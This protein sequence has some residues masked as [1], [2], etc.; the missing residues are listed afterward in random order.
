MA[1]KFCINC[2]YELP[3]I[4]K[5]CPACGT[6]QN[7]SDEEKPQDNKNNKTI[8]EEQE[9]QENISS[10]SDFLAKLG[11]LNSA[12]KPKKPSIIPGLN[13]G[14][15]YHGGTMFPSKEYKEKKD[16]KDEQNNKT[17]Q[18]I[19]SQKKEDVKTKNSENSIAQE[20]ADKPAPQVSEDLSSVS[21]NFDNKGSFKTVENKK[22]PTDSPVGVET[23][24]PI[25]EA[26][27][28]VESVESVEPVIPPVT[29]VKSSSP[30]IKPIIQPMASI[31]ETSPSIKPIAQ[32]MK[33]V[34][35]S[36]P[37]IETA[38][39]PVMQPVVS[40]KKISPVTEP[41]IQ[42]VEKVEEALPV[43]ETVVEPTIQPVTSIKKAAPTIKPV[44]QPIENIEE[45]LPVIETV[46]EPIT[47]IEEVLPVI[48]TTSKVE[49][50][51]VKEQHTKI[52]S[53]KQTVGNPKLKS[54]K[55]TGSR[56]EQYLNKNLNNATKP[57]SLS[58]SED[59]N[60][61]GEDV[62]QNLDEIEEEKKLAS[63]R[64]NK[65]IAEGRKKKTASKQGSK[66]TQKD[67]DKRKIE[68]IYQEEVPD[69][70]DYDGYYENVLT[71]DHD[72]KLKKKLPL[73][74]ILIIAGG[75]IGVAI[76]LYF[77]LKFN[78]DL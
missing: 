48:E 29:N 38:V 58:K 19:V 32:S 47:N 67:I 44:V 77:Y 15:S 63:D 71:I 6:N 49:V 4:A 11:M 25:I 42:P 60:P 12:P 17:T 7:I 28:N 74:N 78:F 22:V 62:K 41:T 61:F 1:V 18:K 14:P 23:T 65:R 53:I 31:E 34:E 36:I 13:M 55:N 45:S 2:G 26:V 68:E 70:P 30:V 69:E 24:S 76:F 52:S 10:E 46:Q 3:S 9:K 40:V 57:K 43:I 8:E 64:Q 16:K 33:K 72:L 35:E 54:V 20:N 51:P 50:A 37:I 73:K 27:E 56:R 5:F 66:V 59:E 75:I 39:E 21:F